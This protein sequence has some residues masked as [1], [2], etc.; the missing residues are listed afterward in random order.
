M[1]TNNQGGMGFDIVLLGGSSEASFNPNDLNTRWNRRDHANVVKSLKD[2]G[3]GS[4]LDLLAAHLADDNDLSPW[5]ADAQINRDRNLRLQYLAGMGMNRNDAVTLYQTI[6]AYRPSR[7]LNDTQSAAISKTL[8]VMPHSAFPS[9]LWQAT[10]KLS[11][12]RTSFAGRLCRVA[13]ML[14]VREMPFANRIAGCISRWARIRRPSQPT[15]CSGLF[16]QRD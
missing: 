2:A 8:A 5:L 7:E 15:N 3:F 4:P 13:G 1:W 16:K 14:R 11:N 10:V 12:M 6:A 9:S